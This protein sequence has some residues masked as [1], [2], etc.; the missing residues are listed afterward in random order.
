MARDGLTA[1]QNESL[2]LGASISALLSMMGSLFIIVKYYYRHE[3]KR[4]SNQL[5]NVLS[6]MDF[7]SSLFF[8]IGREA[9]ASQTLCL[10]QGVGIELFSLG[11]I[12][13]NSCIAYNL[14]RWVVSGVSEASLQRNVKWYLLFSLGIPA[15]LSAI[16]L[17]MQQIGNATLWCWVVNP[18]LRFPVFYY[19]LIA[20]W[21]WNGVVFMKVQ[22]TI[23]KRLRSSAASDALITASA[24][25]MRKLSQYVLVFVLVWAGALL[26]R[27]INA[28][29]G[30]LYWSALLHV[31]TVPLQGFLNAI[32]YGGLWNRLTSRR[33]HRKKEAEKLRAP[34]ITSMTD[35]AASVA[36]VTTV[37]ELDGAQAA[38][39][40]D[41]NRVTVRLF[42]GTWN[43]GE[44]DVPLNLADWLQPD[45][46]V[47]A[48]GLQECM[49]VDEMAAELQRL[50]SQ[51]GKYT[52]MEH[53]IGSTAKTFGYHGY[54]AIL[55][56][57]RSKMVDDGSFVSQ[58]VNAEVKR[59]VDLLVARASNKGAVGIPFTLYGSP[60][61]IVSCHLSSDSS[62]KS[63]VHKRNKDAREVVA[64]MVLEIDQLP[65]DFPDMQ[66]HCILLGDLNYRLKMEPEE[67]LYK[68]ADIA[69]A[70]RDAGAGEEKAE[71]GRRA[72]E[73]KDEADAADAE[74]ADDADGADDAPPV[75]KRAESMAD[76]QRCRVWER[77]HWAELLEADEL[78]EMLD[79]GTVLHGFTEPQID[80]PPTYRRVKG[81]LGDCGDYTKAGRLLS[82]Y[83]LFVEKDGKRTPR[84]PSYTDRVLI[85]SSPDLLDR[86]RVQSYTACDTV[87]A[88]DHRPVT[89]M[90]EIDCFPPPRDVLAVVHAQL[91]NLILVSEGRDYSG[92]VEQVLVLFPIPGEDPLFQMRKVEDLAAALLTSSDELGSVSVPAPRLPYKRIAWSHVLDRGLAV[93]GELPP[94]PYAHMVIKFEDDAGASLGQAC[95]CLSEALMDDKGSCEFAVPVTA[96]G[97]LVATLSGSLSAKFALPGGD[98]VSV[99]VSDTVE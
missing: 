52:M 32:V 44:C 81:T 40:S 76:R 1:G 63:K 98:A 56:F 34:L 82:A 54:I 60:F 51:W 62:G 72:E 48:I 96:G 3:G 45:Q 89:A 92:K 31:C 39:V 7:V 24:T 57:V 10:L 20:A 36:L 26:N 16:L 27:I 2:Q 84:T 25:V 93:E 91:S 71:D 37:A 86:V 87:I 6:I 14:Y 78:M 38:A 70:R 61:C 65:F 64:D 19:W 69:R 77:S 47:Y 8:F 95:V 99:E 23:S 17:G 11:S 67:V 85:H 83:T 68:V 53:R 5:V 74:D 35:G 43:L 13:W 9:F 46:D 41:D 79:S 58:S 55:L 73:G 94:T 28:T 22:A 75:R 80:F 97:S 18:D 59:G 90:M 42:A 12:L 50:V 29:I 4:L 66:H 21:V 88:S 15:I 30:I 33:R 49:V